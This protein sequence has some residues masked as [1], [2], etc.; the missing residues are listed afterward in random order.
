MQAT[1]GLYS[2]FFQENLQKAY[3]NR[4]LNDVN[5]KN[6][7]FLHPAWL[8]KIVPILYKFHLDAQLRV[9]SIIIYKN[10]LIK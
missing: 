3:I 5:I 10:N 9:H 8:S 7:V 1:K 4:K 6:Y 2:I